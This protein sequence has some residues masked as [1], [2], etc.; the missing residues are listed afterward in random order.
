MVTLM[1]LSTVLGARSTIAAAEAEWGATVAVLVVDAPIGI[2]ELIGGNVR[3]D[4]LP[5]GLVPSDAIESDLL[6]DERTT[7]SLLPGDIVTQ[8]DLQSAQ[9]SSL[10]ADDQRALSLPKGPAMPEL[11]IGDRVDLV[12]VGDLFDD[13][14]AASTTAATVIDST[15]ETVTVSIEQSAIIE[16]VDAVAADRVVVVRS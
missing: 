12:V 9:R 2:G 14:A 16:V 5:A 7:R 13:S 3:L 11:F 6:A 15:D 4:D 10:L 8:R 1:L